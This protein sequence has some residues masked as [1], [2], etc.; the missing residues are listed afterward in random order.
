M[1]NNGHMF[2]LCLFLLYW[3]TVSYPGITVLNQIQF[4]ILYIDTPLTDRWQIKRE[5]K[6]L[7][8]VLGPGELLEQLQCI[9]ALMLLWISGTVHWHTIA[10]NCYI[11]TPM[12]RKIFPRFWWW[13]WRVLSNAPLQRCSIGLRPG[14]DVGR[15]VRFTSLE[16]TTRI[17]IEMIFS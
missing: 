17:R 3:K 8:K 5:N 12:F 6:Y 16:E 15:S 11:G 1:V 7:V 4:S 9:L 2:R 13:Q 14:C 10:H